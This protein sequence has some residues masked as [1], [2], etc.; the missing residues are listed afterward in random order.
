MLYMFLLLGLASCASA[1]VPG[2]PQALLAARRAPDDDHFVDEIHDNA[3]LP[4]DK[5]DK[6]FKPKDDLEKD[7]ASLDSNGDKT[8]D[9]SELMWRQ[10]ASGCE[11]I[12]AEVR[13]A[14]YMKCG[15]TNKG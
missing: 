9:L 12:E 14:D 8:L 6:Y 1:A 7:F 5:K 11:P 10:Y 13:A 15:D 3:E 2:K 4:A